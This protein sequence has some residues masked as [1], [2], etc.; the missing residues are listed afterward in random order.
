MADPVP[1]EQHIQQARALLRQK[2]PAE[3]VAVIRRR[4]ASTMEGRDD[5]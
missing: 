1:E 5:R 4:L 3:A 2:Q